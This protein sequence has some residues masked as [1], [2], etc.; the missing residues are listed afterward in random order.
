MV[1]YIQGR[2]ELGFSKILASKPDAKGVF[3]LELEDG[4]DI[5]MN[6]ETQQM[7]LDSDE[8]IRATCTVKSSV[9]SLYRLLKDP[10][11]GAMMFMTK[12]IKVDN[13]PAL[14]PLL[15]AVQK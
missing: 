9:K 2:L 1:E 7:T 15:K 4:P 14:L 13:L 11:K 10:K 8:E 12:K 3:V 5:L 6:L